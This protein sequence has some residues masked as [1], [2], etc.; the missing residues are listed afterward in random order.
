MFQFNQLKHVKTPTDVI[1]LPT[2]KGVSGLQFPLLL[3]EYLGGI[4]DLTGV[5]SVG[6]LQLWQMMM[7]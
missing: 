1:S 3:M 4:M 5:N 7:W 6:T 2:A